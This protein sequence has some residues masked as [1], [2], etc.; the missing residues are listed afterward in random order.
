ML[1]AFFVFQDQNDKLA[2]LVSGIER[3]SVIFFRQNGSVMIRNLFICRFC[4]LQRGKDTE[5]LRFVALF[6]AYIAPAAG[7]KKFPRA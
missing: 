1:K 5:V 7:R 2:F 6:S 3:D 4:F